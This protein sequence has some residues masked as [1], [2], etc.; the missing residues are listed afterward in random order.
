MQ[1]FIVQGCQ[2]REHTVQIFNDRDRAILKLAQI[3]GDGGCLFEPPPVKVPAMNNTSNTYE[4]WWNEL[5][6]LP[7]RDR[8]GLLP[9]FTLEGKLAAFRGIRFCTISG[10]ELKKKSADARY[11]TAKR[12]LHASSTTL[13]SSSDS[14]SSD[15]AKL[16]KLPK[17]FSTTSSDGCESDA[18]SPRP[19]KARHR[20]PRW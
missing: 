12:F 19:S 10:I 6:L 4:P 14:E 13:D 7:Q 15:N 5:V 1:L 18:S 16:N 17:Q 2:Y 11:R 9:S 8:Q 20:F 3:A